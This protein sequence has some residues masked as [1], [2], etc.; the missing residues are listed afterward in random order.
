MELL[1]ELHADTILMVTHNPELTRSATRVLY[2]SDGEIVYD[3]KTKIGEVPKRAR[4]G[5]QETLKQTKKN[6]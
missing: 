3:E 2:M 1:A 5:G 4:S 6:S